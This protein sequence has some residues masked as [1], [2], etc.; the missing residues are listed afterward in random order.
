M[1]EGRTPRPPAS[2]TR[3]CKK[4]PPVHNTQTPQITRVRK[5][6]KCGHEKGGTKPHKDLL[7]THSS[8]DRKQNKETKI[9]RWRR[10]CQPNHCLRAVVSSKGERLGREDRV[11][12]RRAPLL[13]RGGMQMQLK[14]LES[15]C[16][17]NPMR[18]WRGR[19][20]SKVTCCNA[21]YK[22]P[23]PKP[24]ARKCRSR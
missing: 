7:L 13:S 8:I 21:V 2:I 19:G 1:R 12:K 15:P 17:K 10:Q 5:A 14:S 22:P 4:S 18:G 20:D 11:G 9:R 16:T 6:A 24:S 23:K 3:A